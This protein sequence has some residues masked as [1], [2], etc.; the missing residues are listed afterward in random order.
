MSTHHWS[1]YVIYLYKHVENN[2]KISPFFTSLLWTNVS[3][4]TP[5]LWVFMVLLPPSW[6]HMILTPKTFLLTTSGSLPGHLDWQHYKCL[7]LNSNDPSKTKHVFYVPLVRV[8]CGTSQHLF[9]NSTPP[10]H[11]IDSATVHLTFCRWHFGRLCREN[12]S[13]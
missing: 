13:Q 2:L 1:W 4:H 7:D 5:I 9:P 3:I 6:S 11:T 8:L 10:P 12:R